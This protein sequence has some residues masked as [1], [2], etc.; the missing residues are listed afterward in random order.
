MYATPSEYIRDLIWQ[1]M[2]NRRTVL[3]IMNGL[4]DVKNRRFSEK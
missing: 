3:H 4:D 2:E 1:D